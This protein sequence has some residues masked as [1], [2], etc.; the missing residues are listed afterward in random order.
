MS[1]MGALYS[2]Q[3]TR[4]LQEVGVGPKAAVHCSVSG[5]FSR[6]WLSMKNDPGSERPGSFRG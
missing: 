4:M 2:G 6:K 3:L 5:L 1:T